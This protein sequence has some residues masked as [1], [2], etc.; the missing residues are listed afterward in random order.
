[1]LLIIVSILFVIWTIDLVRRAYLY[2]HSVGDAFALLM[3]CIA[4]TPLIAW[5]L[6]GK[7]YLYD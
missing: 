2:R 1:M 4:A 5:L 7:D 3:I 6:I